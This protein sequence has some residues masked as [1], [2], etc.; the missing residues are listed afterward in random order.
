MAKLTPVRFIKPHP[1]Y[2]AREIA[3]FS[4][5]KARRL[6]DQG[7]AMP[8]GLAGPPVDRQV[9]SPPVSKAPMASKAPATP[10]KGRKR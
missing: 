10:A 7:I 2:N 8:H 1:P 9:K 6:I 4:P 5:E 3:G